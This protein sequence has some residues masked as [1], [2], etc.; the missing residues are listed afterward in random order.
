[1]V[2]K[3]PNLRRV[4]IAPLCDQE[5]MA[6]AMGSNYT[7]S[8]KP[9]PTLISTDRFDEE[10]IRKDLRTTLHTTKR[11][12][13]PVELIMKDVHTLDNEPHRLARWVQLAREEIGRNW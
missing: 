9:N 3:L 2:R 12:N 7:F 4:S 11:H 10:L 1:M 13:C 5:I 8:R 6:E